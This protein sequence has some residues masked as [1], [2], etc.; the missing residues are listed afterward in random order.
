MDCNKDKKW[1]VYMHIV[2]KEISGYDWD[3]YY[4]GITSQ[5]VQA[6]WGNG[7][8]YVGCVHFNRA[9]QKYGWENIK[10][11]IIM[12]DLTKAEAC[13]FE[14][15]LI[16]ELNSNDYN[17][18]YNI[19]DGGEGCSGL[20]G[21]K[22]PNYGKKW[23]EEQRQKMQERLKEHPIYHTETSKKKIGNAVK[24]R[25]ENLEYRESM[26]GVNAPCY[27]RTGEKHPMY[28]V[29]GK[30]NPLSKKVVCLNTNEVY[31]SATEASKIR[32]VN[33]SKLCMCCRG[34]RKSC[35]KDESGNPL[36]WIYYTDYL[37][38]NNLTDEEA[39]KSLIFIE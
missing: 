5:S 26:S 8:N 10:H 34:D 6:R 12:E 38:V 2:P 39:C 35:G 29:T 22:N 31:V 30:D 20:V 27:G 28:G 16:K 19:T 1:T 11:K 14:K 13:S 4:V 18:G 15:K 7:S 24:M 9:I 37:K 36:H 25:W 33:L 32:N 23:T 17:Y 3:K 21:E